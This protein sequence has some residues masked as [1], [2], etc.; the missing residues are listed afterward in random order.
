MTRRYLTALAIMS[1]V[2]VGAV[3]GPALTHHHRQRQ[4][5]EAQRRVASVRDESTSEKFSGPGAGFP[6][7]KIA[8]RDFV[9]QHWAR[10]LDLTLDAPEKGAS[11]VTWKN[12]R[13]SVRLAIDRQQA[14]QPSS[15]E[16]FSEWAVH[17]WPPSPTLIAAL[18]IASVSI[19]LIVMAVM[20]W[21]GK[22]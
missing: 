14:E 11:A 20:R 7:R 22:R 16:Y 17:V 15:D 12:Y 13:N 4:F 3:T 9:H 21:S 1:A 2:T 6:Y 19:A 18:V 10:W 8:V 5:A